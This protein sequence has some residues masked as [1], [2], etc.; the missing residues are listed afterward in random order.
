MHKYA[1]YVRMIFT[2][3]PCNLCVAKTK[4]N[5]LL[6]LIRILNKNTYF[7]YC[8]LVRESVCLFLSCNKLLKTLILLILVI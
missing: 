1:Y 3:S 6:V 2:L 4:K 7:V 5:F 8:F